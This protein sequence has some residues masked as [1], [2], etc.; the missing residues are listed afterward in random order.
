MTDQSQYI[1]QFVG[2]K[3]NLSD[4]DFINRWLPFAAGFKKAGIR[5]IDLYKVNNNQQLT[6]ISRNIW[7][8]KTYFKNFPSGIAGSGSGGGIAVIQFGGYW[9]A[10]NELEKS[11]QMHMLFINQYIAG[12]KVQR[13]RCTIQV[14]YEHQIEFT[15]NDNLVFTIDPSVILH[16]R[17][18]KTM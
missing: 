14:P 18:I 6:Y 5:S 1:V 8:A 17:H 16:C 9:I 2:F 12:A 4:A 3:A 15:E 7:E 13:K 11:N 10:Q